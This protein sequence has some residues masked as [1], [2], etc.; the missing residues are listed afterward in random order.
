MTD[1]RAAAMTEADLQSSI[2]ELAQWLGYLIMHTRPAQKA[3]GKWIT[4]IQGD[5]GF[6][7]LVLAHPRTHHGT[8]FIELKSEKGKATPEQLI[9]LIA[10]GGADM[11]G[12]AYLFRPSH[13][14]DGTIERTLKEGAR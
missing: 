4:P 10:L 12:P 5:K 3:D 8:I 6:P 9:W 13:W 7:D 11:D 14:I 1:P 2:I